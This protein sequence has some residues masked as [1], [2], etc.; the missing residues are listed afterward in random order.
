M[1]IDEADELIVREVVD[2][3]NVDDNT[4]QE[5]CINWTQTQGPPAKSKARWSSHAGTC[6]ELQASNSGVG[7]TRQWFT[8]FLI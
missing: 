4:Y 2:S 5:T 1:T 6:R 8:I 3:G 7:G